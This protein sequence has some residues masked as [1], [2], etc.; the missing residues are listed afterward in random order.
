[1]LVA[2]VIISLSACNVFWIELLWKKAHRTT[3]YCL[4]RGS[5]SRAG[6]T[7]DFEG[8]DGGARWLCRESGASPAAISASALEPATE[9]VFCARRRCA[10]GGYSRD[11]EC[12]RVRSAQ[13]EGW[14]FTVDLMEPQRALVLWTLPDRGEDEPQH[15]EVTWCCW[16]GGLSACQNKSSGTDGV[17]ITHLGAW[18]IYDVTV[19]TSSSLLFKARFRTRPDTPSEPML[20]HVDRV[21]GGKALLSWRAPKAPRGLLQAYDVSWCTTFSCEALETPGKTRHVL[22]NGV[23]PSM[24]Y[25]FRVRARNVLE[26]TPL[27]GPHAEAIVFTPPKGLIF[28]LVVSMWTAVALSWTSV[29]QGGIVMGVFTVKHCLAEG[30]QAG[31]CEKFF[32]HDSRKVIANGQPWTK[33]SVEVTDPSDALLFY[34]VYRSP[35]GRPSAPLDVH[36]SPLNSSAL[37]LRWSPPEQGRGPVDGYLVKWHTFYGDGESLRLGSRDLRSL[38]IADVEELNT[39]TVQVAA[40]NLWSGSFLAGE[41]AVAYGISYSSADS[42]PQSGTLADV[43]EKFA[44]KRIAVRGCR[45]ISAVDVN[46]IERSACDAGMN[47][48]V[49]SGLTWAVLT[50]TLRHEVVEEVLLHLLRARAAGRVPARVEAVP[51]LSPPNVTYTFLD[52]GSVLVSWTPSPA[53]ASAAAPTGNISSGSDDGEGFLVSWAPVLQQDSPGATSVRE[54]ITSD[55]HL[56][57]RSL[58]PVHKLRGGS[59]CPD[60]VRR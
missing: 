50:W 5:V 9:Y 29:E 38:V 7:A 52:D 24:N 16:V 30:A 28:Q 31:S 2:I 3:V 18:L 11:A 59:A 56:T 49:S 44:D 13:R 8:C 53:C 54:E 33:A 25:T 6:F 42:V 60:H 34:T 19:G 43:Q 51:S 23:R 15:Y 12:A 58:T 35:P 39:Y 17:V 10:A 26:D 46:R 41:E 48:N 27:E 47:V 37:E 21:G 22:L 57:L 32:V 36:V 20:L 1:M 14:K 45:T 4:C 40:Y 55:T